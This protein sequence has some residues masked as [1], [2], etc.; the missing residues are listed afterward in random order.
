MCS[1]VSFTVE[2]DLLCSKWQT[3]AHLAFH[4]TPCQ[5]WQAPDG[6]SEKEENNNNKDK[7]IMADACFSCADDMSV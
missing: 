6:R 7:T 4:S 5:T 1:V 3:T 2:L